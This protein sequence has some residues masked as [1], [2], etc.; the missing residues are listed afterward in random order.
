MVS[1]HSSYTPGPSLRSS[2]HS[3]L[4]SFQVPRISSRPAVSPP[5]TI[6]SCSARAHLLF[7]DSGIWH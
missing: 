4:L 5:P 7:P 2:A 1:I 6:L 3:L